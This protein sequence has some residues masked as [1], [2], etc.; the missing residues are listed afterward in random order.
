MEPRI[1]PDNVQDH[2]IVCYSNKVEN[3]KWDGNPVVKFF[4]ARD[5]CKIECGGQGIAGV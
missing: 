5:A 3:T 4:I 1:C 2:T